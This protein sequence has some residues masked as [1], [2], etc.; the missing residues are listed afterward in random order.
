[1]ERMKRVIMTLSTAITGLF[2][3]NGCGQSIPNPLTEEKCEVLEKKMI[4]T[5]MFIDKISAM[6]ASQVEEYLAA[7]PD[8]AITVNSEKGRVLKDANKRMSRL[9]AEAAT[10]GCKIDY[11]QK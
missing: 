1:M 6:N 4:R 11:K 3:L 9:E 2:V 7:M 5:D 8:T 10:A